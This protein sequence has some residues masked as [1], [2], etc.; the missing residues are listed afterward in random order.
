MEKEWSGCGLG[1]VD[2]TPVLKPLTAIEFRIR[3]KDATGISYL[4]LLIMMWYVL[5]GCDRVLYFHESW[6]V[7]GIDS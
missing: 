7:L 2:G 4:C 5:L 1:R 3:E 6:G